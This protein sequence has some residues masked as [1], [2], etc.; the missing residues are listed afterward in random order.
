MSRSVTVVLEAKVGE[1]TVPVIGARE[2]TE[3]LDN[4]VEALNR[5]IDKT[6]P[7][8]AKAAAAMKVLGLESGKTK[9]ALEDGIG[10]NSSS[11]GVLDQKLQA[12]RAEVRRLA[13]EFNRTGDAA[14]LEK[15]F[16]ADQ[17]A[18]DLE[19]LTKMLTKDLTAGI[20]DGIS[21]GS[22][23]GAKDASSVIQGLFSTPV[24]GPVIVAAIVAAVA[25]AI[26][27]AN[28]ALVTGLGGGLI[29][30]GIAG[31]FH[32]PG[33]KTAAQGLM[34]DLKALFFDATSGFVAPL[35]GA[36]QQLQHFVTSGIDLKSV[37]APL[38]Q[39]VLPIEKGLEGFFS[40]LLKGIQD[41]V[42]NLKPVMDVFVNHLPRLGTAISDLFTRISRNAGENAS[43]LDLLLTVMEGVIRDVGILIEF[44]DHMYRVAI[45]V[46]LGIAIAFD[47]AFGWIPGVGKQLD[48]N[49]L[50]LSRLAA[51]AAGGAGSVDELGHAADRTGQAIENTNGQ[52]AG[53]VGWWEKVQ[54]AAEDAAT[55][56]D[57]VF[58]ITMSVQ[59]ANDGLAKSLNDLSDAVAKNGKTFEG[60]SK[61]ALANRDA[62]RNEEKAILAVRDAN[63]AA[64][65]SVDDANAK[66]E[67]Q[68]QALRNLLASY[69]LTKQQIDDLIGAYSK[70]PDKVDTKINTPGLGSASNGVAALNYQLGQ[71]HDKQ[72]LIE[73]HYKYVFDNPNSRAPGSAQAHGGIR[74][75][76]FGMIIPPSNPGTLVG[77]PQTGGEAMIPLQGITQ[78]RAAELGKIAMGGY[79]LDVVPRGYRQAW[80]GGDGGTLRVELAFSG[81][82]DALSSLLMKMQRTG[83]LQLTATRV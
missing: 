59:E 14:T 65:M 10:K 32:D 51:E 58:G 62:V 69:G 56:F 72:V 42:S 76:Q 55:A 23:E 81:G 36:L 26:P 2:E 13:D 61:E 11:L 21:T 30:V 15:L 75:A 28:A 43:A 34:S 64:G 4:K 79:G 8:A 33:V 70:V 39:Y 73:T 25:A 53:M 46:A 37:F 5:D 50:T 20:K 67:A 74:R 47:K 54:K 18:K 82:N 63:I 3:K 78:G 29:A 57:K 19:K 71:L 35:Q 41:L 6:A 45:N 27:L 17:A 9:L 16:N 68:Q 24:I 60:N 38:A 12:A 48:D 80:G 31:A 1:Y 49:V 7:A 83:D 40:H 77:E 44:F 22:K 66:Y 52:I